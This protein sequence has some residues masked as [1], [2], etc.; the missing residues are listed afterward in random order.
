MIAILLTLALGAYA[1]GIPAVRAAADQGI[2]DAA[3]FGFSPDASGQENTRALQRAVDQTGTVVVRRPGTYSVAGTV[4][5]GSNTSL[6]FGNGVLLKK[7]AEPEPFTHVLLNKG[8]LTKSYDQH[9]SVEGLQVVVNDVDVRNFLVYGLHGQIAFFYVKDLR[10]E[11]F[12]CLDLGRTQY[13]IHVCTFEDLL[14]HDVIIKGRKDGVHLGRGKRFTIRDGVF[15]TFD[16]AV[17]LNAHDYAVGNPELGWIEEGLVENCHDLSADDT[18]G[19][20]CRILAGAWID[21]RPG[22]EVQQSDTVVSEERLYRVQAQPDGTVYKSIT[23]PTHESGS[24]TL[25]G[26]HWGVVQ[27]DVT[28]TAGVR[29]VTFRDIYL[30]KPRTAFSIHFDFGKYSRSYYPGAEVPQQQQLVFDNIRVL[31]GE[32]KE[33]LAIGTPVDVV[34]IVNS[35]LRNNRI[36]F[37]GNKAMSDYLPT[38]INMVGCVFNQ[39]GPME[40]VTNGVSNKRIELRTSASVVLSDAFSASVSPGQGTIDVASDLRGLR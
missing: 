35:S 34:T 31:H 19:Y 27:D 9:I 14:I 33:L 5:I 6:V 28:Y 24:A 1:G 23:R 36:H 21:W 38:R 17:A 32:A 25:D 20:F 16:D 10:I 26:I 12:R 18:T 15:Q 7:V 29:H 39:A 11:G 37:R 22:M 2:A 4:F 30:E 40:L 8:A 13:G 3:A